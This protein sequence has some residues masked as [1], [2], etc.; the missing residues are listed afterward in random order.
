[1]ESKLKRM[2]GGGRGRGG[3]GQVLLMARAVVLQRSEEEPPMLIP[4]YLIRDIC[5]GWPV[6]HSLLVFSMPWMK[7]IKYTILYCVC[8]IF[9]DSISLRF[10]NRKR[11]RN[12]N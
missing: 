2:G 6:G 1:M 3:E 5:G 7:E 10:Q 8:E 4:P 11:N 9:C 12:R